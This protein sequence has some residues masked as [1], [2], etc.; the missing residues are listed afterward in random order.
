[1]HVFETTDSE[2]AYETLN[3]TYGKMR[4][5]L[6][7]GR[8]ALRIAR[9]VLPAVEL[10]RI[11]FTM[12]FVADSDPQGK[13]IVG[14]VNRGTYLVDRR[15]DHYAAGD[16]FMT[17]P[18]DVAYRARVDSLDAEIAIF[19]P[20]LLNEVA[21]AGPGRPPVPIRFE[22]YRPVSPGAAATWHRSYDFVRD[23]VA[24]VPAADAPLV[25]GAAAR[26]LAA[27]ALH[28]FP[29]NA[30]RDP[31]AADR[32]DARQA[33]LRRAMS[34]IDDNAHRDISP[35]DIAAAAHVSMRALQL[36]FR[37]HLDTTPTGYLRQVR[38]HHAH[39]A[40]QAGARANGDT[41]TAIAARWGF[42]S[43]SR[44]ARDYR[45]LFGRP[46]QHTLRA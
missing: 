26:L 40:L 34:F 28:A 20:E 44:F 38:M 35:A 9:S 27:A 22:G 17:E 42:T 16:L 37:R 36:A 19:S 29:S 23:Q 8:H 46:P 6:G 12:R 7:S 13:H 25:A 32:R 21:E 3:S 11:D 39:R 10:H 30:L 5:D 45:L 43:A 41:V 2:V 31:T 14:R 24:D 1:M 4:L 33:S 15:D 18:P